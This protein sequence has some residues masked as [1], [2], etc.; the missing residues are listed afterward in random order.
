MFGITFFK[1]PQN[2]KQIDSV[3]SRSAQPNKSN[4]KWLKKHGV[5]DVISFCRANSENSEEKTLVKAAGM[6]YHNIPTNPY[7]PSEE[8]VG[9]F[10]DLVDNIKNKGGKAHIHCQHGADRTG[11]YSWIYKHKN[12]IGGMNENEQE[13]IDMG[14]DKF[15]IPGLIEW[16]KDFL[17]KV[18][19]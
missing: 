10:L 9:E 17:H 13:M 2:Y 18:H 15:S 16:I 5:T 14:H 3:M 1:K 4:I 11:M 8:N 7:N 12:N 6:Q 19:K